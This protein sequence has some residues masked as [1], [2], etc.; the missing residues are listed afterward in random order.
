[1]FAR[2]CTITRE[3]E[4]ELESFCFTRL[5]TITREGERTRVTLFYKDLYY[6]ETDRQTDRQTDRDRDRETERELESLCF[7][8]NCTITRGGGG[9]GAVITQFYNRYSQGRRGHRGTIKRPVA[10]TPPAHPTPPPSAHPTPPTD[11]LHDRTLLGQT[12]CIGS[13]FSA[14]I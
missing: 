12:S 13:C 2:I 10:P 8:R 5:C 6:N 14:F 3:R 9:G 1:M 11:I 4:R 7:A